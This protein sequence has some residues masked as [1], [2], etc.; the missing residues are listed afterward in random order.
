MNKQINVAIQILPFTN[1]NIH[2]YSVVDKAIECIQQS[3][4]NYQVCPFETVV[5]GEY[6][7]IMSLIKEIHK[8]CYDAGANNIIC[9]LK[10]Q[11]NKNE[12]VTIDDKMEKYY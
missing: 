4:L 10:I 1:D 11:T 2:P 8:V 3:G 12:A 7:T 9:N 6:D 5:E